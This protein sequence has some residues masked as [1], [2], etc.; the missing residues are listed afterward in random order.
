MPKELFEFTPLNSIS[1]SFFVN[2]LTLTLVEHHYDGS[3]PYYQLLDETKK[4]HT[5]AYYTL[6]IYIFASKTHSLLSPL[7]I[8]CLC[9][10]L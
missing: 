10:I 9:F 8:K 4:M 1:S 5:I 2:V 6:M 7:K 3:K